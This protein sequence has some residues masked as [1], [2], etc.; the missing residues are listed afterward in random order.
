MNT[1]RFQRFTARIDNYFYQVVFAISFLYVLTLISN[2]DINW[3]HPEVAKIQI[4]GVVKNGTAIVPGDLLRGFDVLSFEYGGRS[5]FVSYFFQTFNIKIRLL[6]L[7][8]IPPHPSFSLTWILTLILCPILFFKLIH[9]LSGDRTTAWAG[10]SLF[11]LSTGTLSG[12]TM[13]FHPAKPLALFFTLLCCY[14]GSRLSQYAQREEYFSKRYILLLII[15][16][17]T[18]FA[19]CFTDEAAWYIFICVPIL[20]PGMFRNKRWGLL[21]IGLC[22]SMFIIFFLFVTYLVPII[23]KQ[24]FGQ[25][26]FNFWRMALIKGDRSVWDNYR[27][28]NTF[29]NAWYIIISQLV[30]PGKFFSHN[31]PI[32]TLY[33][34]VLSTYL[35]CAF[36]GLS[37][38]RKKTVLRGLVALVLF[39]I[40]QSLILAKRGKGLIDS[41]F[42]YGN[43]TSIFL[44]LPLAILLSAGKEPLKTLNKIVL[45]TLLLIYSYNF[46]GI[47]YRWMR[48]HE[49]QRGYGYRKY[50]PEEAK[51]MGRNK[52][53]YPLVKMA[54]EKRHDR[55]A[56][57][58]MKP[59]FPLKAH[60]LFLEL[61]CVYNPGDD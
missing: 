52:L 58:E 37:S 14:L 31:I 16:L 17:G 3:T 34:F 8:F 59:L 40:F 46:T 25:N 60:W 18:M 35:V 45:I 47:N 43:L 50:F 30:P 55:E 36:I 11:L 23:T 21:T 38:D 20:A 2:Y 48:N 27:L 9:D 51:K 44:I 56:L 29:I 41:S 4:P 7:R 57:E 5:R 10:A 24:L 61:N 42:Y 15:L 39:F 13:F 1:I 54:W 12:I 33:L 22:F 6:L 26:S 19:A 49:G 53:T 32:R 28:T